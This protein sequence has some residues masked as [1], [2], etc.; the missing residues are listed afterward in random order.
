MACDFRVS[1]LNWFTALTKRSAS[2]SD[3]LGH[4]VVTVSSTAPKAFASR[5]SDQPSKYAHSVVESRRGLEILD[6]EQIGQEYGLPALF[7]HNHRIQRNS[8]EQGTLR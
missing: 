6:L 4:W 2:A 1:R 3:T 7:H 5:A 8:L